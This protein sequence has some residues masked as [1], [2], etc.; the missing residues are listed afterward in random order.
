MCDE[1]NKGVFPDSKYRSTTEQIYGW[2][3]E[4]TKPLSEKDHCNCDAETRGRESLDL[5]E[6]KTG[7]GS[8]MCAFHVHVNH[9]NIIMHEPGQTNI[10]HLYM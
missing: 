4:W 6:P 10:Y 5:E 1:T 3:R 8:S 9:Q 2:E 7:A